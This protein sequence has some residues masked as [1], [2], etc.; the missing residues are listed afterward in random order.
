M[1]YPERDRYT[2]QDLIDIMKILRSPEGCPWDREQTHESIASNL[3]EETYEALEAIQENDRDHMVEE[4]GDVLLQVVFHTQIAEES[5]KINAD[6]INLEGEESA[7]SFDFIDITDTIC[8]KLIT[9]HPH[10]FGDIH[11]DD[12]EQVLKN[13]DAIKRES[14]GSRTQ[15]ENMRG[16]PMAMPALL[17]AGKVQE[18]AKRVG[19]DWP[20][21]KG[22]MQAL[23][24]EMIELKE[25]MAGEDPAKIEDE[26][27]D[28]LFSA[29]NVSRFYRID[30]EKAL[31]MATNKFIDRFEKVEQ[32]ADGAGEQMSDLTL[33]Q[34]N[35]YW[36]LVKEQG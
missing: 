23:E 15:A 21:V 9:R 35:H 24:S 6:S 14:K 3:L 16:I 36:E 18:R 33:E 8:K 20:E 19:F 11:L 4:L 30:P 22:A 27:G 25:S 13:W 7:K 12:A 31:R 32:M 5:I 26:L 17:R 29:V 2:I 34:L 1:K 10:I 28:L